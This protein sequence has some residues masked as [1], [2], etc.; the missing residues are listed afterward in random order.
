MVAGLMLP[1]VVGAIISILNSD[2][3]V[4]GYCRR[5]LKDPTAPARI[6]SAFPEAPATDLRRHWFMPDYAVLIRRAGGA[7]TNLDM[8]LHYARLDIRCYGPG[9]TVNVRRRT[10][11]ELWRVLHPALIPPLYTG[12]PSSFR[13]SRAIIQRIQ[14]EAEPIPQDEPGTDW[15]LVLTPYIV[16][17]MGQRIAA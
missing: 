14:Q 11:E 15:P 4:S 5:N 13:V 6:A 2:P 7:A 9:P 8:D 12:L 10:A 17:Y 1:D 16:W 3:D